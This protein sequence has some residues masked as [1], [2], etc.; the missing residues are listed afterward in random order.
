ME[1]YVMTD[2]QSWNEATSAA[3]DQFFITVRQLQVFD[4]GRFL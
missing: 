3:Y 4:V 1:S 2:G